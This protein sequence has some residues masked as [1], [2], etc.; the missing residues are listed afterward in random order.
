MIEEDNKVSKYN[1]AQLQ[2][3]RLHNLWL[4]IELAVQHGRA[5]L[6][7]WKFHLDEV[8]R[9]LVADV[10]KRTNKDF[11]TAKNK[12]LKL[13][14]VNAKN[15]SDLYE[16]LSVRHEFLKILQNAVGKGGVYEDEGAEDME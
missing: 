7:V 2:I 3:Q 11:L 14:I 16:A 8:W 6:S 15:P 9:E 12:L 13:R 4:K 1:E 5:N 10:E